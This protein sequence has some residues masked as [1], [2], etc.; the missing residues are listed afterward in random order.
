MSGSASGAVHQSAVASN[1]LCVQG[2]SP[3]AT[4]GSVDWDAV[5]S[6]EVVYDGI[7]AEIPSRP[8]SLYVRVCVPVCMDGPTPFG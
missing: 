6:E 4:Q 1:T 2:F 5:G 7:I 3:P 8:A